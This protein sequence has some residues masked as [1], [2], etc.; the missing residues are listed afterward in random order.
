MRAALPQVNKATVNMMRRVEPYITWGH[1]N[2]KTV[3]ELVYK[4][5][6]GKVR[7]ALRGGCRAGLRLRAVRAWGS[8]C[9]EVPSL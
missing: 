5:G 2:L 3:K 1:P 7:T 8:R 4:R 9:R 6:Y